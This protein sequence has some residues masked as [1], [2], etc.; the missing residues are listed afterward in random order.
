[1]N[2]MK[3]IMMVYVTYRVW[4]I[5][6][7]LKSIMHACMHDDDAHFVCLVITY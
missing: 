5:L 6:A 4:D 3:K 1:M 7:N 2:G